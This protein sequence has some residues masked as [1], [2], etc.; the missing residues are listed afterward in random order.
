M[1]KIVLL[2][3]F[4]LAVGSVLAHTSSDFSDSVRINSISN[5]PAASMAMS[6]IDDSTVIVAMGDGSILIADGNEISVEKISEEAITNI[7]VAE[8]IK[9]IL[10]ISA[11]GEIFRKKQNTPFIL[12]TIIKSARSAAML[13]NKWY[14]IAWRYGD[15]LPDT[16]LIFCL[17]GDVWE[18]E[19]DTTGTVSPRGEHYYAFFS[20][21]IARCGKL[22]IVF[23]DYYN[24]WKVREYCNGKTIYSED[25]FG[26]R[27]GRQI[28]A[29]EE[30]VMMFNGMWP[31]GQGKYLDTIFVVNNTSIFSLFSLSSSPDNILFKGGQEGLMYSCLKSGQ[32]NFFRNEE[33][34]T[35]QPLFQK[36]WNGEVDNLASFGNTAFFI[37]GDSLF[38]LVIPPYN[39]A[40]IDSAGNDPVVDSSAVTEDTLLSVGRNEILKEAIKEAI[41]IFPNPCI[42][43]ADELTIVVNNGHECQ[44]QIFDI[45]GRKVVSFFEKNEVTWKPIE[46]GVYIVAVSKYLS[47]GWQIQKILIN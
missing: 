25:F 5:L 18:K 38:K 17:N 32:T 35:Y 40:E 3:S 4:S 12:D 41:K 7:V 47:S 24:T 46:A 29:N 8:Q 21:C 6:A 33:T 36:V 39:V 16:S 22:Y 42:A 31:G 19:F 10:A 11:K 26:L 28:I 20:D 43:G 27:G 37:S 1:M 44:I 9:E 45:C 34:E 23:S 14:L 30:V 2:L 13:D 15:L